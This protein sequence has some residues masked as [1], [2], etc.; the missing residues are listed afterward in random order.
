MKKGGG[1]ISFVNA[2]VA[3]PPSKRRFGSAREWRKVSIKVFQKYWKT[4]FSHFILSQRY[5]HAHRNTCTEWHIARAHVHTCTHT[6]THTHTDAHT[7]THTFF[8]C[9]Y[10]SCVCAGMTQCELVVAVILKCSTFLEVI[11]EYSAVS[12]ILP[13]SSLLSSLYWSWDPPS[14][15]GSTS[16]PIEVPKQVDCNMC[17]FSKLLLFSFFL[18]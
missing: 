13:L 12:V 9:L 2:E 16:V 15:L 4:T 18:L 5:K 1:K 14:S 3:Y 6:H 17:R 11:S 10:S 8:F 7:C